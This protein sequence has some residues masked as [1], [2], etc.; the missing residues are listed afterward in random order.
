MVIRKS[1]ALLSLATAAVLT[2]SG[3]V[4]SQ[5]HPSQTLRDE[6]SCVAALDSLVAIFRRD[7]PGFQH[8]VGGRE[9]EF[10]AVVEEART[11]AV[12]SEDHST[13]IPALWRVTEFFR[14]PHVMVWQA[15]AP[16][17][18]PAREPQADPPG[19]D[20]D[21]PTLMFLDDS[22]AVLQ[23]PSFDVVYKSQIEELLAAHGVRLRNRPYLIVDVRGN[24]GGC[25]CAFEVLVP[26]LYTGPIHVYGVE[27]WSS[28]AN[29]DALRVWLNDPSLPTDMRS[30]I[31]ALLPR[32]EE[33]PNR[34]VPWLP[35]RQIVLDSVLTTPRDV[36]VLVDGGCASSCEDFVLLARQSQKVTVMG[37]ERT[38]GVGDYGNVRSVWLPGWRRLRI[39]I[40]RSM[41]FL[42][43]GPL[44]NIG[45]A[46]DVLISDDASD[47][48]EYAHRYLSNRS[49]DAGAN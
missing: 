9:S 27:I 13:C 23:L 40:S 41:R 24:G 5:A 11:A 33:E 29:E 16:A 15:A 6:T 49:L 38:K 8:K 1:L 35:D 47:L 10:V 30:H 22:T 4:E 36:A 46:P 44:D 7:Y 39:P 45:I 31:A 20:A 28:P 3:T 25:T 43:E 21:R 12:E 17:E 2:V 42:S 32:L 37:L 19:D 34:F 18:G 26:L 14:D 48:V